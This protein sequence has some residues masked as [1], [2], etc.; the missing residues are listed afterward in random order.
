MAN[1]KVTTKNIAEKLGVSTATVHRAI[2]GKPGVG[3]ALRTRILK[4]VESARYEID[5]NASL[6]RREQIQIGILLPVPEGEGRYFFRGLWEGIREY[7]EEL[8]KQKVVLQYIETD[9]GLGAMSDALKDLYDHSDKS[10]QGLV[11]LCDDEESSIWIS[12]FV[13]RGTRVILVASSDEE[14]DALSLVK[15][16]RT[17]MGALAAR[18]VNLASGGRKGMVFC[19]NGS[20]SVLSCRK[21]LK[22]FYRNLQTGLTCTEIMEKD[23]QSYEQRLRTMLLE[24]LPEAIYCSSA[25]TT[26]HVCRIIKDMELSGKI[27]VIGTDVF[28][29]LKSYFEDETLTACVDQSGRLQGKQA[30]N[31]LV[32]QLTGC[33]PDEIQKIVNMPIRL[34][35]KENYRYYIS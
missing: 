26:Y 5:E 10:L 1:H 20:G 2:Y 21:I 15:A 19:V 34:V 25:R 14:T 13:R 16:S 24:A 17:D 23:V 27:C 4:E 11:T 7:E 18:C 33:V 12:R 29:E 8:K 22:G 30:L 3:E 28:P 35:M 32:R 6:L 31:I 9:R